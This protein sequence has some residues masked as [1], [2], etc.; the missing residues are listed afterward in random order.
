MTS[1]KEQ[2]TEKTKE[3]W[4]KV[5]TCMEVLALESLLTQDQTIGK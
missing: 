5:R 3:E 4:S 2:P 1:G